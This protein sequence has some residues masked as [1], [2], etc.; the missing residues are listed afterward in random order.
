MLQI[1]N[2]AFN[3]I[4]NRAQTKLRSASISL[5][6]ST[7]LASASGFDESQAV[8][9]ISTDV[10]SVSS[11]LVVAIDIWAKFAQIAIGIWLLWRQIGPISISPI[12]IV[13]IS[14]LLQKQLTG[15]MPIRQKVWLEAVQQRVAMS[16]VG[17]QQMKA[18]KLSGLVETFINLLQSERERELFL[19][20]SYRWIITMVNVISKYCLTFWQRLTF[21]W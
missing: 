14:F 16:K 1:A 8:T 12:L 6:F 7:A 20:K 2:G 4:F 3:H 19:A 13:F 21:Q 5:I 11:T 18:V 17:L 15:L 9:L 10:E